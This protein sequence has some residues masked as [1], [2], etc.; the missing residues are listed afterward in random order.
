MEYLIEAVINN[1]AEQVRQLLS[2][3]LDPNGFEDQ[4]QVRP[5]HF[6][7]QYNSLASAL[8]LLE[9]GAQIDV[10]TAD[11]ITPLDVAKL[12]SHQD[13]IQLFQGTLHVEK[14]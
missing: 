7:A 1:N 9:A 5:L 12:H 2:S 13:M 8:V 4:A 11:G 3:G 10:T 14:N 6:A